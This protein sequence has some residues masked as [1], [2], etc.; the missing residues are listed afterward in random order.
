MESKINRRKG[1]WLKLSVSLGRVFFQTDTNFLIFYFSKSLFPR[2][3][4]YY[5]FKRIL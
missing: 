5:N 2:K 3:I 4:I 1:H